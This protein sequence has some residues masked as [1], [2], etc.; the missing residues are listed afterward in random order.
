M[1]KMLEKVREG[2]TLVESPRGLVPAGGSDIVYQDFLSRLHLRD[3]D[4]TGQ[5]VRIA[6]AASGDPRFQ[7]FLE[8]V[9][10]EGGKQIQL[11]TAAKFCQIGLSEFQ[12]FWRNAKTNEAIGKAIDNLP[13][14]TADLIE[15]AR[16]T[17]MTCPVCGGTGMIQREGKPDAVCRNCSGA[18]VVKTI[19][20][21]HARNKLLEMTGVIKKD[22]PVQVNLN[23]GGVG[24]QAAASKLQSA[25]PFELEPAV[26]IEAT[27]IDSQPDTE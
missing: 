11:A 13:A 23:M 14:L 18:G 2:K 12:A 7:S 21:K 24:M 10:S 26:D 19:G 16:S 5:N 15:D 9:L 20:D 4:A 8:L 1:E 27:T 3:D 6:L 25:V 22:V 17:E